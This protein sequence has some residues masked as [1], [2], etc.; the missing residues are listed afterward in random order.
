MQYTVVGTDLNSG[1]M[2][3]PWNKA[4]WLATVVMGR[5]YDCD[6]PMSGSCICHCAYTSE[7]VGQSAHIVSTIQVRLAVST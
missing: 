1:T 6:V 4:Q 2:G 7:R 3:R 5:D